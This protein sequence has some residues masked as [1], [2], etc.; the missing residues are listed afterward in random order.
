MKKFSTNNFNQENALNELIHGSGVVIIESVFD[1]D[2]I[3]KARS[4]VNKIADNQEQKESQPTL[5]LLDQH[6]QQTNC[7]CLLRLLASLLLVR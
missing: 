7:P 3:K 2:V 6:R 1:L 4:V 5:Q